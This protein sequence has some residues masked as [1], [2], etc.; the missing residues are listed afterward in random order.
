VNR[1]YMVWVD[2][3]GFTRLTLLNGTGSLIGPD[4][5]TVQT[6]LVASSNADVLN[7]VES[8][9][10]VNVPF[11]PGGVFRT[12]GDAAILTFTDAGGSLV[13]ITLPAPLASI[14]LADGLTVDITQ[15]AAI[16]GAVVG[17]VVTPAGG[18]VTAYVAGLRQTK[19]GESY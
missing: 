9:L 14:F 18:T 3:N 8:G 11:P 15:I 5:T 13:D 6:T 2:A 1:R 12:V 19:K 4:L 7:S 17:T 10:T 16:I